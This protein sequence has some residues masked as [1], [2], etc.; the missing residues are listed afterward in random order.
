MPLLYVV[1][2]LIIVAVA[3]RFLNTYVPMPESTPPIANIVLAL[4]IVGMILW[5]INNYV[6]MAASIK[7]ILNILVVAV[8]CVKV[9]QAVG[10]LPPIVRLWNNLTHRISS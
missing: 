9:L 4:L 8:T 1:L 5:V 3:A 7:A 6:P 2:A 10:L